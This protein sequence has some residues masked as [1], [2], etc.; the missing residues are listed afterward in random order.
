MDPLAIIEI[1]SEWEALDV[2]I[3]G[4]KID[5]QAEFGSFL[6]VSA[7]QEVLAMVELTLVGLEKKVGLQLRGSMKLKKNATM[8]NTMDVM[9]LGYEVPIT[10]VL[11]DIKAKKRPAIAILAAEIAAKGLMIEDKEGE[12]H[13]QST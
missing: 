1:D 11:E 4:E 5:S 6:D 10:V 2:E 7:G 12:A 8:G 13:I 9:G 3:M